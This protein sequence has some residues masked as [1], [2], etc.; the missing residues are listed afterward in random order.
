VSREIG[1]LS[2][3]TGSSLLM[4]DLLRVPARKD[5]RDTRGT[6]RFLMPPDGNYH[7]NASLLPSGTGH[8]VEVDAQ[9]NKVY[10][11]SIRSPDYRIFR[12][13]DLNRPYET[14]IYQRNRRINPSNWT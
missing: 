6:W 9:G 3:S 10:T 4:R 14:S 8:A 7:C 1:F 2:W 13:K 5:I 11:L 12:V